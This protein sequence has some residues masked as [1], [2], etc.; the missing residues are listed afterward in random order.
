MRKFPG[1]NPEETFDTL[2][3]G[4]L[5]IRQKK[6]G[7]RFSIDALLLARFAEPRLT[8]RVIDLGTGCGVIPLI[9]VFRRKAETVVGVEVQPSLA[10]LARQ[11]VSLNH[12]AAQIEIREEDFRNLPGKGG[13][14]DCALCNPPYRRAGSGRVNPQEEKALARHEINATLE[15]VLRAAHHLLKNKGRFYS[16]YPAT[17]T[18]DLFQGLRRFHLE[19]KRVQFVHSRD[20]EEAR[21]VLVEAL[22]EGKTQVKILPPF[23]LYDSEGRY[24]LQA[25]E[26]FR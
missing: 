9:L 3:G 24:T 17:R 21:L 5:E 14:F 13:V 15:D 8:D 4:R 25:E 12:L 7:Y 6:E 1:S 2:F 26:V 18:A 10:A 23:V 16:I 19:P 11:N 20:R 22:K